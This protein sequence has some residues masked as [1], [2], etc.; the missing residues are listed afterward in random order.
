MKKQEIFRRIDDVDRLIKNAL[1]EVIVEYLVQDDEYCKELDARLHE[2]ERPL[3]SFD[4]AERREW[5][6]NNYCNASRGYVIKATAFTYL[7]KLWQ[8]GMYYYTDPRR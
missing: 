6:I 7:S 3:V 8:K 4:L 2:S 1:H 5:I